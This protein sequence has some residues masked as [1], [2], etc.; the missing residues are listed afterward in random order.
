MG[1]GDLSMSLGY[2]S[3]PHPWPEQ[4]QET[5]ERVKAACIQNKVAFLDVATKNN[6]RDKI[7]AGVRVIAGGVEEIAQIGRAYSGRTM[8]V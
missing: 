7:H 5:H 3:M 1:P 4:M 8:P 2:P 6:V